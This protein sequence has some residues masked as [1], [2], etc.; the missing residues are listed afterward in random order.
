MYLGDEYNTSRC[1][2]IHWKINEN[3]W[4]MNVNT[5]KTNTNTWN[6]NVNTWKMNPL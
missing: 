4:K 6:M 2:C 3:T 1:F 5:W